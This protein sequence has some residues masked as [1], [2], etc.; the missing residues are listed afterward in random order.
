MQRAIPYTRVE[1]DSAFVKLK[2]E[3]ARTH[4]LIDA[5]LGT[6]VAR[7]IEGTLKDLLRVV[8]AELD[9]KTA[10]AVIVQ[11]ARVKPKMTNVE[12]K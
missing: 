7:P 9:A 6:G 4:C 11:N 1:D 10:R 2:S 5:L 3:L 12:K 8:R